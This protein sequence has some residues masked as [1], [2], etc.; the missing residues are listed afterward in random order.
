MSYLSEA[1]IVALL[2]LFVARVIEIAVHA[3][4]D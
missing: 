2:I 3:L 1:V 4:I